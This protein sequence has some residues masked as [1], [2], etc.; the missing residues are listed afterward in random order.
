MCHHH[1]LSFGTEGFEVITCTKSYLKFLLNT[2]ILNKKF[3][4]EIEFMYSLLSH[5]WKVKHET[6]PNEAVLRDTILFLCLFKDPLGLSVSEIHSLEREEP[7]LNSLLFVFSESLT[8][9]NVIP[10]PA[11]SP[12]G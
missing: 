3:L 7:Y 4:F 5:I 2:V 1:V 8:V 10:G 6:K 11:T 9:S 12:E